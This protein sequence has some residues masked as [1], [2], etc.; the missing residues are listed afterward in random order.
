MSG[1][2]QTRSFGDVRLNARFA[3]KRTRLG[4]FMST[5]PN[6]IPY[7]LTSVFA[8]RNVTK[9][10]L[11]KGTFEPSSVPESGGDPTHNLP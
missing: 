10:E 9:S 4:R 6:S 1:V 3:R 5:R 2:G 7:A 8:P 11:G